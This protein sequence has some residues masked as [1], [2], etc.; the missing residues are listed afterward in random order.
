[1]I[2]SH[3]DAMTQRLTL[4]DKF[5]RVLPLLEDEAEAFASYIMGRR[6]DEVTRHH[7]KWSKEG[8]LFYYRT[9]K[10]AHRFHCFGSGAHGDLIDFYATFYLHKPS[11]K[12]EALRGAMAWLGLSDDAPLPDEKAAAKRRREREEKRERD[13]A[14]EARQEALKSAEA[15]RRI[16]NG[17]HPVGTPVEHYIKIERAIPI[18]AWPACVVYDVHERAA[19]FAVT[20]DT[21]AIRSLQHVAL[22]PDGKKDEHR[23][24]PKRAKNNLGPKSKGVVR[25]AGN[26][27]GYHLL[28]EGPETAWTGNAASGFPA[29]AC[30][31]G[32]YHAVNFNLSGKAIIVLRDD[33]GETTG[34]YRAAVKAIQELRAAGHEVIEAWPFEQHRGNGDDFNTLAQESGIGAVR[35]RIEQAIARHSHARFEL[36]ID[37]TEE[38]ITAIASQFFEL[39]DQWDKEAEATPP[40]HA[41]GFSVG[42]GKTEAVIN[43]GASHIDRLRHRQISAAGVHAVPEHKLSNE[44]AERFNRTAADQGLSLVADVWRGREAARPDGSGDKMCANIDEVKLAQS[45]FV[46]DIEKEVCAGCKHHPNNG[47][48]CAYLAQRGKDADYWIISHNLLF[49]E[50]PAAINRRG[51]GYVVVDEAVWQAG[52]IGVEGTGIKIAVDSL[53]PAAGMIAPPG[54]DGQRLRAIR[55][56]FARVLLDEPDGWV[57]REAIGRASILP[58]QLEGGEFTDSTA[59]FARKQEWLRKVDRKQEP[60]WRHRDDNKSLGRMTLMW[61]AVD[62]IVANPDVDTSGRLRLATEEGVRVLYVYG[63]DDIAAGWRAPT[64]AIDALHKPDLLAHYFPQIEDKGDIRT[65]TP[66]MIVEQATHENWAKSYMD[67][68]MGEGDTKAKRDKRRKAKAVILKQAARIGG[69]VLLIG[70]KNVVQAIKATGLP[71]N[72]CIAWYNAVA[73][74]DEFTFPDGETIKG[75]DLAGII[76]LGAPEPTSSQ[77]ERMAG[78]LTGRAPKPVG[79]PDGRYPKADAERLLRKGRSVVAIPADGKRHPD[80][81]A[82]TIR[83]HVTMGQLTQAAGRGRGVRRGPDNPLRVIALTGAVLPFPVDSFLAEADLAPTHADLQIAEGG[84]AFEDGASAA[85]AYPDLY[86]SPSAARKA[87]AYE[88]GRQSSASQTLIGISIRHWD[89]LTIQRAGARQ[90]PQRAW[91]LPALCPDPRAAIEAA[92]GPLSRFEGFAVVADPVALPMAVGADIMLPPDP[93]EPPAA[94]YQPVRTGAPPA[95]EPIPAAGSDQGDTGKQDNQ[96]T[97]KKGERAIDAAPPAA[98]MTNFDGGHGP[99]AETTNEGADD[100]IEEVEEAGEDEPP[101]PVD[102]WGRLWE[103][104]ADAAMTHAAVAEAVKISAC[105]LSNIEKGRRRPRN[106]LQGRIEQFIATAAPV[107]GRLSL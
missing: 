3:G 13:A 83:Q 7:Y 72:I 50:A 103:C 62:Y 55:E 23:Y 41:A 43:H 54:P 16:E 21:G 6:P 76:L 28:S 36:P 35:D 51:V 70:A 77:V 68:T 105:H 71:P 40:V 2:R 88:R 57:S 74:R 39:A 56:D 102:V 9:G 48:V 34:G 12:A 25:F 78:A 84:I 73:G 65:A 82:E 29:W 97:L 8:G 93:P 26:R 90:R 67:P 27:D 80:D 11:A 32:M 30:L 96:D 37:T 17:L 75:V 106:G 44:I 53:L 38:R 5:N 15:R 49:A 87:F 104:A 18:T 91:V 33:D 14:A 46:D 86:P 47:G 85:A 22:T 59:F 20:D 58:A 66:H 89:A 94:R 24:G 99:V 98:S 31:G 101:I 69:N 10:F 63:R 42:A 79:T 64:I 107:Q 60:N 92:I 19:A 100:L 81:L 45:L 95:A 52:L 61:S 1:M 4:K